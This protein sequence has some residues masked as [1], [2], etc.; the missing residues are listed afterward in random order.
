MKN[1][2]GVVAAAAIATSAGIAAADSAIEDEFEEL[3]EFR[4]EDVQE[5]NSND[6]M[7]AHTAV[8][9]GFAIVS[10]PFTS[11][12]TT[13]AGDVFLFRLNAGA[14][15]PVAFVK[16]M[17]RFGD[18]LSVGYHG[19]A[20]AGHGD[21]FAVGQ[22][23]DAAVTLHHRNQGGPNNW[24]IAK[25]IEPPD[26]PTYREA[27][28]PGSFGEYPTIDIHG[29]LLIV[30]DYQGDLFDQSGT[31]IEN[32]AGFAF[33]YDR[34][35]GGP[36]EWGLVARLEDPTQDLDENEE[37]GRAV[38][39]YDG[40]NEDIAV[41]GAPST[42]L[43][44]TARDVGEAYVFSR[45]AP[46]GVWTLTRT[47]LGV[48]DDGRQASDSFGRSVDVDGTTIAVGT[49]N[50]ANDASQSNAGSVHIFYRDEGGPAN[51]GEV[52]E[53]FAGDFI[54]DFSKSLQLRGD[55]LIVGAPG[56]GPMGRG[57][58][59]IYLRDKDGEDAWGLE[60]TLFASSSETTDE[61]GSGV[62]LASGFA[63][64]GDRGR[65]SRDMSASRTGSAYFFFDDLIFCDNFEPDPAP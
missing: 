60:D 17:D 26:D 18:T 23:R 53:I 64:V 1:I 6:K 3:A 24:G 28:F 61:F 32:R 51:W 25:V 65:T 54:D 56:G 27:T 20:L 9:P 5:P 29:D 22:N 2:V 63:V 40:P 47:L 30:S 59:Y 14:N 10:A 39:I 19:L 49:T 34:N 13:Q 62:S 45:S 38:A 21:W 37:F 16:T 36:G 12:V 55:Q 31:Q 46:G 50:G 15:P 43:D 7:G 41:V 42:D 57:G 33:I 11:L 44:E 58:A 35:A 52:I 8:V 48:G 4:T